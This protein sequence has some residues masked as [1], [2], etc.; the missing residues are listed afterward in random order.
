MSL[1][2]YLK[3]AALAYPDFAGYGSDYQPMLNTFGD[4]LVQ[5][6]DTDYQGDTRILYRKG[7]RYGFLNFG[8]G[9]CS[10]CDALAAC[11]SLR[12]VAELMMKL[13]GDIKW[14]DSLNGAKEYLS[15]PERAGSYYFH[16][17]EWMAFVMAVSKLEEVTE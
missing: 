10:G 8:W 15:D 16:E 2:D 11:S 1:D 17:Q 5:V 6:D 12:D 7:E 13:E 14:F 3:R 4:I 9:S